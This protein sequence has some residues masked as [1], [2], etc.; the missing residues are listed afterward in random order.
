MRGRNGR[1]T[2]GSAVLVLAKNII[3][4]F[5]DFVDR[6]RVLLLLMSLAF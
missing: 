6:L 3:G 5:Y 4:F 1:W 2:E